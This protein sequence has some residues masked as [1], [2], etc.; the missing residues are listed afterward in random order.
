MLFYG[1]KYPKLDEIVMC[2]IIEFDEDTGFKVELPEYDNL[3]ALLPVDLVT[4]KKKLRKNQTF[5]SLCPLN[6]KRPMVVVNIENHRDSI[7]I[8]VSI[9]DLDDDEKSVFLDNFALTQKLNNLMTRLSHILKEKD[10]TSY[11]DQSELLQRLIWPCFD[12][13]CG[14]VTNHPFNV[15]KIRDSLLGLEVPDSDRDLFLE[16]HYKLFGSNLCSSS[17]NVILNSFCSDGAARISNILRSTYRDHAHSDLTPEQL[18]L[19]QSGYQAEIRVFAIPTYQVV[20]HSCSKHTADL[21]AR[22]IGQQL[23]SA[24]KGDNGFGKLMVT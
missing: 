14:D 16:Y 1:E 20:V 22:S 21:Q 24:I 9:R 5:K 3:I 15:L 18:Y 19:D 17:Q 10:E 13:P 8:D 23:V 12:K 4:R 2:H 7:H 6:S 11:P